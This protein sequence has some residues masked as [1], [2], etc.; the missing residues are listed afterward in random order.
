[1][2]DATI[3]VLQGDGVGPEV[4]EQALR[5]LRA[6]EDVY[7]H[8]FA[9]HQG[10]VGLDAIAAE[11]AAISDATFEMC[12]R[13][14]AVLFGAVGGLPAGGGPDGGPRPEQALFRLRK[15][16]DFFAN[17]RP[18]RSSEPMY[19]ASP[20]KPEYLK[21]TDMIFVRELS[22]GLYYGRLESVPGKPSEIRRTGR[23][24]EAVDTLLYTEQEIE[25]VV[26]AAFE[27]AERRDRK[28]TS[29]DKAN[30]L[31]SSVLW[32]EVV[33]QVS[34]DHPAVDHEHML[35]DTCAMELI[36]DPARFDVVVTEN[37]FGDIL[38]DEASML[39]GSIG[40]LPSASLGTRRVEGGLFGLYEPVH[41]SA[42]DIAGQDRANPVGAVLSAALLL[43]HSLGLEREAAAVEAAVEEVVRLGYRTAD[44]HESG[45]T[46]V[47][48][49]EMGGLIR[50]TLVRG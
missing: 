3:T 29:V 50:E 40:M 5:A 10:L 1:M 47:G 34:H 28:V 22:A 43:R 18:V 26:R 24:T 6:V 21:G 31:S 20:V 39:T 37:L 27:I 46:V 32:R 41:G 36:R 19:G 2:S 14:D 35:V 4:T 25:R 44:V 11:G 13:S 15:E 49:R 16:F 48:T 17:L 42:P 33:E 38:T 23:G 9:V 30:V 12:A 8:S 7:G 45:C